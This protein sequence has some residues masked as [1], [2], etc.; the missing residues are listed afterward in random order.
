MRTTLL[1]LSLLALA[2]AWPG[3]ALAAASAGQPFPSNLYTAPDATQITGLRVDR[4]AAD[5]RDASRPTAPTSRCS[6][7]STASTSSRGSRSRSRRRST[8]RPSRARTSSSSARAATSS[9]STRR[10]GSRRPTRSTSRATSSSRRTRRTC[11][12]SRGAST[13]PTASRS[14]RRPF[15]HDLNFGQTKD[16]ATKAYRKALL[17]AL[18]LA[19]VGGVEPRTTSPRRASSRRRAST[20]SPRRS[21]RSSGATPVDFNLG[22]AGARTVFPLAVGLLDRPGSGRRA[23]RPARSSAAAALP[24]ACFA[25]RRRRSRSARTPHPTTRRRPVHPGGWDGDRHARACRRRT[26]SRSRS[27]CLPARAPAGGWPVAIFGHG[28]G[29]S[30]NGAPPAVAA[31]LARNGHRHDRD[32]RRRPRR[33]RARHLHGLPH[34]RRRR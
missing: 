9:G 28:F 34:R 25:G 4:A 21:A 7:R 5:L 20:R 32:Q 6:T 16:P 33:R 30:K 29:D 15:R 13:T 27:S 10:S 11:S 31:S 8:P 17:D 24:A 3:S 22:T 1:R 14:T 26:S 23:R 19:I 12:S 18:P 2:L